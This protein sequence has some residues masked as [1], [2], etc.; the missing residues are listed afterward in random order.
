MRRIPM[1]QSLSRVLVHLVFSTKHRAPLIVPAIRDNL[2]AFMADRLDRAGCPTIKFGGVED[3]VH[4]L[5]GL[6][7]V[8][9][10]AEV[11]EEVKTTSCVWTKKLGDQFADF[12]WQAGYGAFSV[13]SSLV[14]STVRYI[15]RQEEHHRSKTFQ[16]E[17]R[18]FL[19]LH[20]IEY[21]ERFVWD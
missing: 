21:D 17:F 15:E 6:S 3:H 19:D 16:D 10:V 2:H 1:P 20:G 5:F 4:V 8:K 13:C 11:V 9:S 18:A 14:D 7:R 12:R